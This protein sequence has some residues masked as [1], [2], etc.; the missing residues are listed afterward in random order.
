MNRLMI[1]TCDYLASLAQTRRGSPSSTLG[2]VVTAYTQSRLGRKPIMNMDRKL[3]TFPRPAH[4]GMVGYYEHRWSE[5]L[6]GVLSVCPPTR[7]T[8]KS[9]GISCDRKNDAASIPDKFARAELG[10]HPAQHQRR[11]SR[12]QHMQARQLLIRQRPQARDALSKHPCL[13]LENT[14]EKL[15]WKD[16]LI[17][18]IKLSSQYH[19]VMWRHYEAKGNDD[20]KYSRQCPSQQHDAIQLVEKKIE[21]ACHLPSHGTLVVRLLAFHQGKPGS[22]PGW[23]APD[24]CMCAPCRTM[25]LGFLRDL[26]FPLR[27]DFGAAPYSPRFTL[28]SSQDLDV[29]SRRNLFTRSLLFAIGL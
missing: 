27:F 13:D 14:P 22:I 19:D 4:Q 5:Q 28:I 7:K 24:F 20:S 17:L 18:H 26:P 3:S 11:G 25:P 23:V 9:Q 8:G 10:T 2:S 21:L 6:I 16:S 15:A 29:M 1:N 12:L